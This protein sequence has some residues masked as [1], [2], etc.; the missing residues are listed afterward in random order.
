MSYRSSLIEQPST[1]FTSIAHVD[2]SLSITAD[3]SYYVVIRYMLF[4]IRFY[5]IIVEKRREVEFENRQFFHQRT[6]LYYFILPECSGALA[7]CL[8]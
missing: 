4:F 2:A 7:V 3:P 8:I 5:L 1:E 6:E